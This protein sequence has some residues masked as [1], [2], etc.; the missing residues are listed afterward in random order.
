MRSGV[1]LIA[2]MERCVTLI[3]SVSLAAAATSSHLPIDVACLALETT[4]LAEIQPGTMGR[5][6]SADTTTLMQTALLTR[7]PLPMHSWLE[8]LNRKNSLMQFPM[9]SKKSFRS[10]FSYKYWPNWN[11]LKK[12]REKLRVSTAATAISVMI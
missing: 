1:R 4:V 12:T 7:R 10:L 6:S 3:M 8:T 5:L 9:T 2:A 11:H